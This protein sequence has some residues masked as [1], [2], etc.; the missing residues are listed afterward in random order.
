MY[1]YNKDLLGKLHGKA[2]PHFRVS[3]KGGFF[4]CVGKIDLPEPGCDIGETDIPDYLGAGHRY[5]VFKS[6]TGV[7]SSLIWTFIHCL[8]SFR[9]A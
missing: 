4:K 5:W 2:Q 9:S 3:Y 8:V 1:K 6:R 7:D